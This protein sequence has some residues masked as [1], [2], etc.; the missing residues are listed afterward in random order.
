MVGRMVAP[1]SWPSAPSRSRTSSGTSPATR[2]RGPSYNE[3]LGEYAVFG[4]PE[5]FADRLLALREEMGFSTL[6]TWMNPGGRI[7]NERVLKSMRLFAER[8]APRLA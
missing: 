2:R 3:V 8:V 5:A 6:S 4:T 1:S 7:P